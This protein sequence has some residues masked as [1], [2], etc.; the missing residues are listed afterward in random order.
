MLPCR[1]NSFYGNCWNK[2][3]SLT[4]YWESHMDWI[5]RIDEVDGRLAPV[6]V[7][8]EGRRYTASLRELKGNLAR[9]GYRAAKLAA[10]SLHEMS[11][12]DGTEFLRGIGFQ[13]V[14]GAGQ[15]VFVAKDDGRR[16]LIPAS[17][18]LPALIPELAT[19]GERL[20]TAASLDQVAKPM[21]MDDG[22]RVTF[23]RGVALSA[24]SNGKCA[25]E[26]YTWLTCYPS[27]RRFWS[28]VFKHATLG[29]LGFSLPNA[30]VD[31]SLMG[32]Q[33]DNTVFATRASVQR[34]MPTE[35]PFPFAEG[36]VAA[37][38]SFQSKSEAAARNLEHSRA[39]RRTSPSLLQRLSFPPGADGWLTSDEEWHRIQQALGQAGFLPNARSKESVDL[40]I[41]KLASGTP[42]KAMGSR[43]RSAEVALRS[44][45]KNG[46]WEVL[47]GVLQQT[48]SAAEA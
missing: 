4:P 44:W 41:R 28:S 37:E 12:T 29:K 23:G 3:P 9:P 27:A 42:W 48:R 36:R 21:V 22:V 24:P 30:C 18:L 40:A 20:L 35:A 11:I 32:F 8:A 33:A 25:P 14:S 19:A 16:I 2:R 10:L 43:W 38:F 26:R 45:V 47:E 6:Y 1:A 7:T 15:D 46:K 17:V 34:V 39:V 5:E 31:I 13:G